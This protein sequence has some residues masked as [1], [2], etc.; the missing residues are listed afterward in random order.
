MS[1]KVT[2]KPPTGDTYATHNEW[3]TL[4][5]HKKIIFCF[6]VRHVTSEQHTLLEKLGNLGARDISTKYPALLKQ[7]ISDIKLRL[8]HKVL[9]TYLV[10][11]ETQYFLIVVST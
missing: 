7:I 1:G 9:L 2:S 4:L 5:V 3:H 6:S 8:M 10:T 11:T